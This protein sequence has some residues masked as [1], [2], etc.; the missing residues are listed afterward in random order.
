MNANSL[1]RTGT[2]KNRRTQSQIK[3]LDDQIIAVLREDRPQ[4]IRHIFYRMTDPRLAEPVAKTELGYRHVQDRCVKLRRKGKIPYSWISDTSRVGYHTDVF[5]DS[6]NFIRSVTS[7]YRSDL[8]RD[9][10][11]QCE[12]WTESRSIASVI[13]NEC[14]KLAVSLY[15]CGG[16]TSLSFVHAAAEQHNHSG[17]KKPLVVIYIG[18]YDPAGVLIDQSLEKELRS[19]LNHDIELDFKRIAINEYMIKKYDLPTK[20]RKAG[21]KRALHIDCSVEAE[22][23]PA[24]ILRKILK[25]EIEALLP[26][27]ALHVAKVA[28]ESEKSH[29]A[30]IATLLEAGRL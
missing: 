17:I 22:A 25:D 6:A 16:F 1:Y 3:T 19:H 9:A 7:L 27:Q 18:D 2:I 4:S 21:D 10:E 13:K 30:V 23:L 14:K 11:V 29:L 20:P 8:W 28:E 15:P 12:V 24:K 26:E 5:H